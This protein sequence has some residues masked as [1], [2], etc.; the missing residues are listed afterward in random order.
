MINGG[1]VSTNPPNN[2]VKNI[3]ET[4]ESTYRYIHT[5]LLYGEKEIFYAMNS[6]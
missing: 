6:V 3:S 5:G 1:Y 4:N 2:F